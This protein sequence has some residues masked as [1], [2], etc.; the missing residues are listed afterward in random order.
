M[1]KKAAGGLVGFMAGDALTP[2]AIGSRILKTISIPLA[3]AR[4]DIGQDQA[5]V[6][7]GLFSMGGRRQPAI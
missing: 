4:P 6:R 7:S 3:T 5:S 1:K 2:S